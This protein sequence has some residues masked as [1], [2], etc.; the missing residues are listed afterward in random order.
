M[1]LEWI[2]QLYD[3]EDRAHDWSVDTRRE[4]RAREANPVL[5]KNETYLTELQRTA[6]LKSSLYKG[7]TYARNQAESKKA[8]GARQVVKV[9][10]EKGYWRSSGKTPH[11]TAYAAL[12]RE[13]S[14]ST[15]SNLDWW[16]DL[17]QLHAGV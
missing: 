11:T 1:I 15:S 3:I 2:R 12:I 9:A 13:I 6:L 14:T 7:V 5:D 17:G 4:L 16:V 10:F 8:R